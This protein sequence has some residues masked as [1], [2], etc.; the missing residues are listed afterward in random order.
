M[1]VS[2]DR[3]QCRLFCGWLPQPTTASAEE[4]DSLLSIVED[5]E[6]Q[7][8]FERA[9]AIAIWYYNIHKFSFPV[10]LLLI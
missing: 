6:E 3:S 8:S 5:H 4:E 10:V 7:N 9:A 2:K 1:Y